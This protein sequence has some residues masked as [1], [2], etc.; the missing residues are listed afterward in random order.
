MNQENLGAASIGD[1]LI[2]NTVYN[3]IH[4]P[5]APAYRTDPINTYYGIT[6]TPNLKD[7]I[8]F[9]QDFSDVINKRLKRFTFLKQVWEMNKKNNLHTHILA[10]APHPSKIKYKLIHQYGWNIHIFPITT[11][12]A[13]QRWESYLNKCHD[14]DIVLSHAAQHE[15]LFE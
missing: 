10:E 8:Y 1:S 4:N 6:I 5:L 3:Y 7:R 2:D 9:P 12:L 15:N 14:K 13:K 11:A